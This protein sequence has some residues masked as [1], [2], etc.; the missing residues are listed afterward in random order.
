MFRKIIAITL[1]LAF[2]LQ[3]F[4]RAGYILGYYI[5]PTPFAKNCVNK[6]VQRLNCNGQCQLMKKIKEEEKKEQENPE[7]KAENKSENILSRSSFFASLSTSFT[8]DSHKEYNLPVNSG[9]PMDHTTYIF[10]PPR[11]IYS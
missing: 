7:R 8:I 9:I 6:Y 3:T 2:A 5:D 1:F 11:A 10:H 4:Q